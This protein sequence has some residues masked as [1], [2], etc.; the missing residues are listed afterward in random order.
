MKLATFIDP[1]SYD[2]RLGVVRQSGIVDICSAAHLLNQAVPATTVMDALCSG[3]ATL[4]AVD[5]LA[6]NGEQRGL[7]LDPENLVLLSPIPEPSKFLCIGKNNR[8]HREEL[9]A[10][11]MLNEMPDEP[12]GFV[13]IHSTICGQDAKIERP[14][15][16][17][18]LDYEPELVFVITKRAH[19]VAKANAMEHVGAI[20]LFNDVSAR[21][22]QKR[23]VASG[24][25]FWTAKNMPNFSPTGPYAVT[26]DEIND[27]DDLWV[28]CDVNGER[29]LREN[30][31]DYIYK[32]DDIIEHFSRFMPL[33]A[34]DLVAMGAPK[35]VAVGQ[36]NADEL[37]LKPGDRME[38]SIEGL[39]SL[40]STIVA[41][42]QN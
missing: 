26:L 21:E 31:S 20:T 5:E 33:E 1:N 10:N 24:T 6:K 38:I 25:R 7:A 8:K 17:S 36:P 40:R 18:M 27:P 30:T 4:A 12:T 16:I 9:K 34:G 23:E 28:T 13:K 15:G 35:G 32:I 11:A 29:R 3:P 22:I 41:P 37:Y 14:E 39:M 42:A 19:R 2:Q